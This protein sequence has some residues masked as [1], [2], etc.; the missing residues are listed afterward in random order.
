MAAVAATSVVGATLGGLVAYAATQV[1]AGTAKLVTSPDVFAGSS[2]PV[3]V[4]VSNPSGTL[5]VGGAAGHPG[6][7]HPRAGVTIQPPPSPA[8]AGWHYTPS[9]SGAALTGG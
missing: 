9:R 4:A 5:G 2:G 1:N 8:P 6:G 7:I 3:T